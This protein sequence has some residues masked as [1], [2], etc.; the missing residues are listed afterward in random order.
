VALG[1]LL[2]AHGGD[3]SRGTV[4]TLFDGPF[5]TFDVSGAGDINGD[6]L[7]DVIIGAGSKYAHPEV[8]VFY[9]RDDG[10]PAAFDLA[11]LQPE[12]G[13]D[14]SD[15]FMINHVYGFDLIVSNLAQPGDVN[16][17][18]IDDILIGS[19]LGPGLLRGIAAA[20]VVYGRTTPFPAQFELTS[21]IDDPT[22]GFILDGVHRSEGMQVGRGGDVDG[23]GVSDI[24][25]GAY[26]ADPR[27]HSA[28]GTS[29]VVFGGNAHAG[30]FPLEQ[31]SP[32]SGGDGSLGTLLPGV[33]AGDLSGRDVQ[34]VRDINADGIDDLVIG[35]PGADASG[36][37]E[38]GE[39]CVVFGRP[40]GFPAITP[41]SLLLPGGG[42]GSNG[43]V[44]MGVLAGDA[45]GTTVSGAGDLNGDGIGDLL[46]GAP[47]ADSRT[48]SSIGASYVIFGRDS[49]FPPVFAL[50]TLLPD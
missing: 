42:D 19:P 11:N 24:V 49:G 27:D 1:S 23:D 31:L 45:S 9:G 15:G 29:Y 4:L 8:Y 34:I 20:Y 6:G 16:G 40:H 26:Y 18:G 35:A 44:V 37:F 22:Q 32:Q 38:A 33:A 12:N 5:G 47:D 43:F 39:T 10:F 36:R 28:A 25:L 3:G 48:Q 2:P 30:V 41:L 50:S 21:L 46:I 17:D 7:A 13:G 14:G